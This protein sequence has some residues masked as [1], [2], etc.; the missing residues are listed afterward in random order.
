MEADAVGNLSRMSTA[1]VAVDNTSGIHLPTDDHL[2][3]PADT[4]RESV[5][6]SAIVADVSLPPMPD[7][8]M[9]APVDDLSHQ[10]ETS[11]AEPMSVA[12]APE[13]FG[14]DTAFDETLRS[15]AA[16]ITLFAVSLLS[17]FVQY[18]FSDSVAKCTTN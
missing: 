13:D 18:I 10:A 1:P 7:V 5:E 17:F 2:A 4:S 12:A 6:V 15:A 14:D 8:G 3:L 9:P 16:D 11:I